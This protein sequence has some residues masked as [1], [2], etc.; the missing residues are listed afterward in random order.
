MFIDADDIAALWDRFPGLDPA[1]SRDGLP[2]NLLI[3]LP[4]HLEAIAERLE[5]AARHVA[6]AAAPPLA[7]LKEAWDGQSR[8]VSW[9]AVGEV[10]AAAIGL[11]CAVPRQVAWRAPAAFA[12]D[13]AGSGRGGGGEGALGSGGSPAFL[14]LRFLPGSGAAG[15]ALLSSRR[16]TGAPALAAHASLAEW[17]QTFAGYAGKDEEIIAYGLAGLALTAAGVLRRQG[18]SF[19]VRHFLNVPVLSVHDLQPIETRWRAFVAATAA[20]VD[21]VQDQLEGAAAEALGCDGDSS[22]RPAPDG[23]PLPCDLL[24]AAYFTLAD[25]V[26]ERWLAAGLLGQA[27]KSRNLKIRAA[28]IERPGDVWRWL[29]LAD[30]LRTGYSIDV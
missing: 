1:A 3:L 20:A 6:D 24:D 9:P 5:G 27:A 14:R 10:L 21:Q 18:I 4:R 12:V 29:A 7:G 15:L 17:G 13:W 22:G 11:G 23:D 2:H 25:M 16:W 19:Q 26:Y 8:P 28:V 30:E